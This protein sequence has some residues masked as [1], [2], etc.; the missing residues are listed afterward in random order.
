MSSKRDKS[1]RRWRGVAVSDGAAAGRV[2][3]IHSGGRTSIYRVKLE[4]AE[5]A[6]EVRRYEAAVRLARRQLLA[7]KKRAA[8]TS[9]AAARACSPR[10]LTMVTRHSTMKRDLK[11]QI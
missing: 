9:F 1:E 10:R 3:R 11:F 8:R 2:L 4:G 5:V 7:L 6:R